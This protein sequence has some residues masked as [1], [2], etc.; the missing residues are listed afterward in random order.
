MSDDQLIIQEG[1][2]PQ[3][4]T[5]TLFHR[6]SHVE[7]IPKILKS[8]WSSG[9]HGLY[10]NGIYTTYLLED[11][12]KSYMQRYGNVL[13]KFKYVKLDNLLCFTPAVAKD[14]HKDKYLIVDQIQKILPNYKLSDDELEIVKI[15]QGIADKATHSSDAAKYF[16]DAAFFPEL[17]SKLNGI[18]YEGR[19]DGHCV[20]IYPP[21]K[22]LE[23]ISYV[24]NAEITSN[25]DA[26]VKKLNWVSTGTKKTFSK[27]FDKGLFTTPDIELPI[28]TKS[29]EKIPFMEFIKN[30]KE[31][32]EVT[33]KD[34][35]NLFTYSFSSKSLLSI[36]EKLNPNLL[37]SDAF[38][39]FF[40]EF[41]VKNDTAAQLKVLQVGLQHRPSALLEY[42]YKSY[43]KYEQPLKKE[44]SQLLFTTNLAHLGEQGRIELGKVFSR[45]ISDESNDTDQLKH[46]I[47]DYI[48]K[49]NLYKWFNNVE[50]NQTNILFQHVFKKTSDIIEFITNAKANNFNINEAIPYIATWFNKKFDEYYTDADLLN[51]IELLKNYPNIGY[52]NSEI[53]SPVSYR[54]ANIYLTNSPEKI[55]AQM[56][57]FIFSSVA[58]KN[59]DLLD[60]INP[61]LFK[62]ADRIAMRNSVKNLIVKTSDRMFV[63]KIWK[64][65]LLTS[66]DQNDYIQILNDHL[67]SDSTNS[68]YILWETLFKNIV[69]TY[70]L[71]KNEVVQILNKLKY[72]SNDLIELILN[73]LSNPNQLDESIFYV[74][75]EK[76]E[77]F[78][79]DTKMF[80]WIENIN[81]QYPGFIKNAISKP[82]FAS[83]F[84]EQQH[85]NLYTDVAAYLYLTYAP[86]YIEKLTSKQLTLLVRNLKKSMGRD[87]SNPIITQLISKYLQSDIILNK[88]DETVQQII[89]IV[90]PKLSTDDTYEQTVLSVLEKLM[91]KNPNVINNFTGHY[92]D[93]FLENS[94]NKKSAI[95]FILK[96]KNVNLNS[97]DIEKLLYFAELYEYN[98]SLEITLEYVVSRI[99][100]L[101]KDKLDERSVNILLS[102]NYSLIYNVTPIQ[103][104]DLLKKYNPIYVTYIASYNWS[105][106]IERTSKNIN[107]FQKI[108]DIIFSLPISVKTN[109]FQVKEALI[110]CSKN[111]SKTIN[112][113]LDSG[114][115]TID[116]ATLDK[117]M[118]YPIDQN[119]INKIIKIYRFDLMDG[120]ELAELYNKLNGYSRNTNEYNFKNNKNAVPMFVNEISNRL[121]GLSSQE[122]VQFISWAN[123]FASFLMAPFQFVTM[124]VRD[125]ST[126]LFKR[127]LFSLIHDQDGYFRARG[128]STMLKILLK[129]NNTGWNLENFFKAVSDSDFRNSYHN[130][131]Q[132]PLKLNELFALTLKNEK[133]NLKARTLKAILD[134][135]ETTEERQ[136]IIDIVLNPTM[137]GSNLD[138]ND[139]FVIVST[140][141][142]MYDDTYSTK[143][144]LNIL[145]LVNQNITDNMIVNLV[146]LCP[147][148][149]N[150]QSGPEYVANRILLYLKDNLS[151]SAIYNLIRLQSND[152]SKLRIIEKIL[153]TDKVLTSIDI[154]NIITLAPVKG[155]RDIVNKLIVFYDK[156]LITRIL[157]KRGLDPNTILT[158]LKKYKKYYLFQ[159]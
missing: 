51:V 137:K 154:H 4:N 158:E 11:Q 64:Y 101:K 74:L 67:S 83:I 116:T 22:G 65:A 159:I 45:L 150:N 147:P 5:A 108:E 31:K 117:M 146:G 105:Q 68:R 100:E 44:I 148:T 13:I 124:R 29:N 151:N 98:P 24:K 115:F 72:P 114:L 12:F 120:K 126:D 46:K 110:N 30:L 79:S 95:D 75:L 119:V 77:R 70:I 156:N 138:S 107:D 38:L 35:V 49:N 55:T 16:V 33:N 118:Q 61:S 63:Q 48:I 59:I 112:R 41:G 86:D 43:N 27:A 84:I 94:K 155:L 143:V 32:N 103:I 136:K 87:F 128:P 53:S 78:I 145:R 91:A 34:V 60:K 92:I 6:T 28:P 90:A 15:I 3:N 134:N 123:S 104:I 111:K 57:P 14:V 69:N 40:T 52:F 152:D 56:L 102:H 10:G 133:Q 131:L 141:N 42:L 97:T 2:F 54:L 1:L 50:Y 144:I 129:Y 127:M 58:V 93:V 73:E 7:N 36:F 71:S 23:L 99:F 17:H 26:D 113:M 85:G 149:I 121:N 140:I 88:A 153:A 135:S 82:E 106:L 122:Q 8:G 20:V 21:G 39:I 62:E 130:I 96:Y 47:I 132:V 125:I 25:I 80:K 139:V 66:L 89:L 76:A 9:Y 142:Q 19:N 109:T 37:R 157:I 18:E 81:K